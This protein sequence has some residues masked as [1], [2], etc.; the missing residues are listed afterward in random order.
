MTSGEVVGGIF[1]SGDE[2]FGME[3]LSVST[4]SNF[5]DNSWFE[6]N[7]DRSGDVFSGTSFRE[8]GVEGIITTSNGLIRWHLTIRLDTMFQAEEFPTG[9]TDL[10]TG[11]TNVD[12]NNFSHI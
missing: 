2:L 1:L 11:L 5:I 10:D 9:V 8:K 3:E 7:E 4:S 6:I 12:R